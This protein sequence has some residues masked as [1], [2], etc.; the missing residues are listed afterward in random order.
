MQ[1]NTVATHTSDKKNTYPALMLAA[2]IRFCFV[3]SLTSRGIRLCFSGLSSGHGSSIFRTA[4]PSSSYRTRMLP[5]RVLLPASAL[6]EFTLPAA[7]V[8]T[9]PRD[10]LLPAI[11]LSLS[12]AVYR[13]SSPKNYCQ[14]FDF[15]FPNLRSNTRSFEL[16]DRVLVFISSSDGTTGFL[17]TTIPFGFFPHTQTGKSGGQVH[18]FSAFRNIFLTIRSSRE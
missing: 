7:T 12:L 10:V 11:V 6:S 15:Q 16:F 2:R 4:F 3:L 18:G 13:S 1:R 9:R 8:R 14:M 5:L 17:V